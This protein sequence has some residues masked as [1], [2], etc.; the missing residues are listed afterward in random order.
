MSKREGHAKFY[1]YERGGGAEKVLSMLKGWG[2][3]LGEFLRGSLKWRGGG[4]RQFYPVF[5]F[6][7]L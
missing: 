1:P 5:F 4:H 2:G 7:F 6:N 3:V